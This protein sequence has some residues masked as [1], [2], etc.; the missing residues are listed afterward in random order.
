MAATILIDKKIRNSFGPSYEDL[1]EAWAVCSG[2][3]D[4]ALVT[5]CGDLRDGVEAALGCGNKKVVL[6]GDFLSGTDDIFTRL[7]IEVWH[8]PDPLEQQQTPVPVL[9]ELVAK[10]IKIPNPSGFGTAYAQSWWAKTCDSEH[11][12]LLA[13]LNRLPADLLDDMA[14]MSG[15]TDSQMAVVISSFCQQIAMS[16]AVGQRYGRNAQ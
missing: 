8:M 13:K 5:S 6:V 9:S 14:A 2:G 1:I 11:E 3:V 4:E 16:A 10:P 15:F 12:A 7:G